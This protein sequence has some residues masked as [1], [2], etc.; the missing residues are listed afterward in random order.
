MAPPILKPLL[1]YFSFSAYTPING[2]ESI[3][4][5]Y[6]STNAPPE[7]GSAQP[8]RDSPIRWACLVLYLVVTVP[9]IVTMIILAAAGAINT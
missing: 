3:K 6:G 5:T 7:G 9:L 2:G 4:V 1:K 8:A